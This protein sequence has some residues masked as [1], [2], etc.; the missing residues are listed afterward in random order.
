MNA[1]RDRIGRLQTRVLPGAG[2]WLSWWSRSLAAW[3]PVRWRAALG[4]GRDRLLLAQDP[5]ALHLRLQTVDGVEG[6]VVR[7]IGRLP[8]GEGFGVD[9]DP[10]A[11]VLAP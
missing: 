8:A 4:L 5:D 1:V 2:G 7:D 10:L 9:A 3:L 11:T 6:P